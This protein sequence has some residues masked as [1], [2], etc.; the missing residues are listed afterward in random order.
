FCAV[1]A[2]GRPGRDAFPAPE[3]FADLSGRRDRAG[4]AAAV[5]ELAGRHAI[6]LIHAHLID[7]ADAARLAATGLPLLMTVH[8]TRPGW[9]AGLDRLAAGESALVVACSRAV[10]ADLRA[11]GLPV[12]VRTVWNGIDP[13]PFRR[14]PDLIEAGR[15]WRRCHGIGPD[16]LLL[17]AL[18]NPRPQKRLHLLPA[19]LAAVRAELARRGVGRAVRLVV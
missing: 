15:D 17:A 19:V 18:A 9:P 5:A 16:D 1:A 8:N 12:P 13:R 2:L 4:R 7:H 11:A 10:E 3:R 14:T 6:D